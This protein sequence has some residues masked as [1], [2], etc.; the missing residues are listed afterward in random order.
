MGVG[1]DDS[2]VNAE[3]AGGGGQDGELG[4]VGE[5]W[6]FPGIHK[7][8]RPGTGPMS[9]DAVAAMIQRRAAAAGYTPA[10]VDLLGGHSLRSGFVTEAFRA[11]ADAHSIMPQTDHRDPKMLEVYAREHAPLVGNAVTKLDL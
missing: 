1:I 8:G 5:R 3:P 10:Q 2:K 7:T 9:G 6:L 11:G 4:S